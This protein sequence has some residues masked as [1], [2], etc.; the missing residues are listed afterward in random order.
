MTEKHWFSNAPWSWGD[1]LNPTCE[2]QAIP[3]GY[4][5]FT[6]NLGLSYT[7]TSVSQYNIQT[8]ETT[9]FPSLQYLNQTLQDCQIDEVDLYMRKSDQTENGKGRWWSWDDSSAA[10]TAHC[11]IDTSIGPVNVTFSTSYKSD[12]KKFLYTIQNNYTSAASLWW[13]T[14]L[15][16]LYWSSTLVEMGLALYPIK[17]NKDT[18]SSTPIWTKGGMTFK[19]NITSDIKSY[20]YFSLS[21]YFIA[22]NSDIKNYNYDLNLMYNNDDTTAY[23]GPLTEGLT[24]AKIMSS[25]V[26]T[27][28]GETRSPNLL[29]DPT[30]LQWALQ[31]PGDIFR[32]RLNNRACPFT[33]TNDCDYDWV[34]YLG[35]AAPTLDPAA[36]DDQQ[37]PMNQSYNLF[38][39]QMGPLGTKKAEIYLQYAC[40]IP[41]RKDTGTLFLAVLI[42]DLVFLQTSWM[43][44]TVVAGWLVTRYD[45]SAM[46]CE[47]H[48]LQQEYELVGMGGS[49]HGRDLETAKTGV[50]VGGLGDTSREAL[51]GDDGSETDRNGYLPV[52]RD[53]S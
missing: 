27:D 33:G 45:K 47:G 36:P 43:I 46:A 1:K 41:Q 23:S 35:I 51:I 26:L 2:T 7:L 52:R 14:R 42:G 37:T 11:T 50:R 25:M 4:Q 32:E 48:V 31:Y 13:G 22:A 3:I 9:R 18:W 29:Q 15:L 30:L 10:A 16:N 5:F 28:L 8:N 12:P 6:T 38:K 34:N 49:P 39:S 20:D 17:S 21:Y 53:G 44:L 40:S 24:W 19:P